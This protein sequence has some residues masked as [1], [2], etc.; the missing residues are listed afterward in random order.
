M[1]VSG[2]VGELAI[3]IA[4]AVT[5]HEILSQGRGYLA[6]LCFEDGDRGD[7]WRHRGRQR[8]SLPSEF[9]LAVC[10]RAFIVEGTVSLG[11]EV[12]AET[13]LIIV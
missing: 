9:L 13:C 2:A 10:E 11:D 12:P 7:R 5:S 1:D 3:G 4:P 6:E 8:I